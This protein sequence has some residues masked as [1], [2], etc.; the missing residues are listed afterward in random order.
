MC[1]NYER[2]IYE[3]TLNAHERKDHMKKR[4]LSILLTLVLVFALLPAAALA[5]EPDFP[6][7]VEATGGDGTITVTW[8]APADNG[9]SEII[10]Y[11]LELYSEDWDVVTKSVSADTYTYTFTGLTNDKTYTVWVAASTADG[12]G[13]FSGTTAV[14]L[15]ANANVPDVPVIDALIGEGGSIHVSWYKPEDNGSAISS[16][17]MYYIEADRAD[18]TPV[19]QWT[20]LWFDASYVRQAN[21]GTLYYVVSGLDCGT[22]YA[23]MISAGNGK[24]NSAFS[25]YETATTTNYSVRVGGVEMETDGTTPV[26]ATTDTSGN[27]KLVDSDSNNWNIKLEVDGIAP[28]L[29]LKNATIKTSDYG[30]YTTNTLTIISEGTNTITSTGSDNYCTGIYT[31]HDLYIQGPGTL[32][33]T[34]AGGNPLAVYGVLGQEEMAISQPVNYKLGNLDGGYTTV[35][36]GD[37]S[38]AGTVKFEPGV[39]VTYVLGDGDYIYQIYPNDGSSETYALVAPTEPARSG[40]IFKGWYY[41][42]DLEWVYD[43]DYNEEYYSNGNFELHAKW[44]Q[45]IDFCTQFTDVDTS[46]WYHDALDFVLENELMSGYGDGTFG[47]NDKTNR[48]MIVNILWRLEGKPIYGTGMSETFP[49]VPDDEWYTAAVEWAACEKIVS[50][51]PDGTFAPTANITRE[52]LAVI[53]FQ[54]AVYQ[55]MDTVTL[56]ENLAG[57]TDADNIS[58]YAITAMNWAVGSGI[59][60]GMGD[61]TLNPQ[62]TATRAQLAQMLNV[63]LNGK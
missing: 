37:G 60:S 34:A 32:T 59:M 16:Y 3:I 23:V 22:E 11:S 38:A 14:P 15:P 47:P 51:Y 57:F 2:I 54:Y 12:D 31:A 63:Y 42:A 4:I 48:A 29:T 53:L 28:S 13:G 55:G 50:G 1:L 58:S 33:V 7:N 36:S 35:L 30:V 18:S 49:D 52:Q 44:I 46:L 61:N 17:A 25:A 62:G 41:D 26:Y 20:Y 40:Y 8:N 10:G 43:F 6:E 5:A 45:D 21:D 24:G 56:E 27:V 39:T 19:E 9:G